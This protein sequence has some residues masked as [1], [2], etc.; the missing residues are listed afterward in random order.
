MA[1]A[2]DTLQAT[3]QLEKCG[4]KREQAETVAGVI[5]SVQGDLATKADLTAALAE[6]K[7]D[8]LN[9]MTTRALSIAGL[10]SA[11]LLGLNT[12]IMFFLL[13]LFGGEG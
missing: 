5:Q 3:K 8:V 10:V 9:S 13:R 12:A 6:L 11:A 2:F 7:T 4:F 1:I